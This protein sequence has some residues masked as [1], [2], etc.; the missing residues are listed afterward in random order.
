[1]EAYIHPSVQIGA[2]TQLGHNS[3]VL[4]GARIG[5]NCRIG[6]GVVTLLRGAR[7]GANVTVLPGITIGEDALVAAG[8]TVTRDVPCRKI[9]YGTPARTWRDV[10]S[11]QLLENQ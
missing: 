1:M 9:V 11:E 5:E 4:E 3:V 7:I 6:H 2:G 8:A 10:P